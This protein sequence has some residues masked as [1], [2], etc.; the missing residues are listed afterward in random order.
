MKTIDEK[1]MDE[2][3]KEAELALKENEVPIGAILVLNSTHEIIARSHNKKEEDKNVT[4]HAE[5]LC[6]DEASKKVNNWR[7]D[8][9][10][11]YVTAE[12]CL[13]CAGAIIQARISRVVYGLKESEFGAFGG[14]VDLTRDYKTNLIVQGGVKEKEAKELM[15]KFFLSKRKIRENS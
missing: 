9:T 7:L 4:H 5:I 8:D 11:L 3:L 15:Q 14:V 12:P 6:I 10:T 13:M 2:A 1:Y